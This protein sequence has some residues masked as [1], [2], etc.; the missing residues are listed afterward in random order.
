[1]KHSFVFSGIADEAGQDL[2]TQIRAHQELGWSYLD[3]RNVDGRQFT[4]VSDEEF[5]KACRQLEEAGMQV[6]CFASGIANWAC[7][8]ADPLEKSTATLQRALPRMQRLGTKLI[9]VMS[10]PNRNIIVSQ[11]AWRL[12]AIHR[13]RVLGEMAGQAGVTIVVEN[14]DGWASTS[15]AAYGEFFAAVNLPSV[16]AVFDTGNPGSHGQTNTWEWYQM[17]KPHLGMI[18]IKAHTGPGGEHVWCDAGASCVEEVLRDL[19]ASG[20][21]GFISIEPHLKAVI[22]EGREITEAQAAYAT[23]VEYGRRLMRLCERL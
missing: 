14:C 6:A 8:I 10:W 22:H 11:E 21:A 5:A 20:Y 17:A 7:S 13:M 23:Y 12:E 9:R 16:K 1:M 3:L 4:D 15:A 2:A 19:A 18:H